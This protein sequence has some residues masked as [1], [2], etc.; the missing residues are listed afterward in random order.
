MCPEGGAMRK[1]MDL[2]YCC[3][4]VSSTCDDYETMRCVIGETKQR[5]GQV[6]DRNAYWWIVHVCAES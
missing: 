4:K 3:L 1:C 6:L 2:V 5:S